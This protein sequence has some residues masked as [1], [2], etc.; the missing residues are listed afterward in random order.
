MLVCGEVARVLEDV[1]SQKKKL[2]LTL[3][4]PVESLCPLVRTADRW[5]RELFAFCLA[6]LLSAASLTVSGLRFIALILLP[7]YWFA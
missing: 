3:P 1:W 4:L 7:E 5:S 6:F 2:H